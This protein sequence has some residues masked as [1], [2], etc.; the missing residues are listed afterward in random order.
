[1][2]SVATGSVCIQGLPNLVHACKIWKT[3]FSYGSI[4]TGSHVEELDSWV[5]RDRGWGVSFSGVDHSRHGVVLQ[6]HW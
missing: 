2:D 6:W 1:M 5:L 4:N 3:E